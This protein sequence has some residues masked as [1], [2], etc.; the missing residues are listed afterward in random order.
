MEQRDWL[1]NE[2][3]R[4][5]RVLGK[6]VSDFLGLKTQETMIKSISVY[7]K[8]LKDELE[9]DVDDL[10]LMTKKSLEELVRNRNINTEQM[11][12]LSRYFE[13]IGVIN[14]KF[15]SEIAEKYLLKSIEL[16]ELADETSETISFERLQRKSGISKLL[17]S[18]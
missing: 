13:K 18:L 6:I 3:E 5:G 15:N 8:R 11:E 9:I 14:M 4:F 7:N 1:L 12:T 16:L 10:V 2:I 17:E